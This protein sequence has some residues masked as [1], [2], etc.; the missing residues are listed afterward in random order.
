MCT[1]GL[2]NQMWQPQ[3]W[4]S[5]VAFRADLSSEH[6]HKHVL[7]TAGRMAAVGGHWEC[8]RCLLGSVMQHEGSVFQTMLL[9][10]PAFQMCERIARP[11][12]VC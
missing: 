11:H 7:Q 9:E 4:S 8:W 12:P 6:A 1:L 5:Q 10:N 2:I 3:E